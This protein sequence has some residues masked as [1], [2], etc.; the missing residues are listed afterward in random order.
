MPCVVSGGVTV[1]L[2]SSG[3]ACCVLIFADVVVHARLND[4][5][6]I[7]LDCGWLRWIWGPYDDVS[8]PS[9]FGGVVY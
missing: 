5:G 1:R 4:V 9:Q 2:C 3:L 7:A 8:T 6:L